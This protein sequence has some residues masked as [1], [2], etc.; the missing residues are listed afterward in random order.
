MRQSE[1]ESE[2]GSEGGLGGGDGKEKNVSGGT[3][4]VLHVRVKK[5]QTHQPL[6]LDA[7]LATRL[8]SCSRARIQE[9][10]KA[11][12]ITVNGGVQVKPAFKLRPGDEVFMTQR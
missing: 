5:D 3:T 12:K 2:S 6:R 11:G 9:S 10:V 4:H 1:S 8:P 7:F